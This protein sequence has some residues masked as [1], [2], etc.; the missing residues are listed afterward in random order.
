MSLPSNLSL[1]IQHGPFVAPVG[2]DTSPVV[3]NIPPNDRETGKRVGSSRPTIPP[4][5]SS[6]SLLQYVTTNYTDGSSLADYSS[7]NS[8]S[9]PTRG[10]HQHKNRQRMP[11]PQFSGLGPRRIESNDALLPLERELTYTRRS[12]VWSFETSSDGSNQQA[13]QAKTLQKRTTVARHVPHSSVQADVEALFFNKA[14]IEHGK[15][16]SEVPNLPKSL[17][18]WSDLSRWSAEY[19][20]FSEPDAPAEQDGQDDLARSTQAGESANPQAHGSP[21]PAAPSPAA[22]FVPINVVHRELLQPGIASQNAQHAVV[23]L[24]DVREHLS[25][26]VFEEQ[27]RSE[28]LRTAVLQNI[29]LRTELEAAQIAL[30]KRDEEFARL[31]ELHGADVIPLRAFSYHSLPARTQQASLRANPGTRASNAGQSST[32]EASQKVAIEDQDLTP[33]RFISRV[34]VYDITLPN[35]RSFPHRRPASTL[36]GSSCS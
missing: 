28:G 3:S 15:A 26:L 21:F 14:E 36:R 12:D 16:E 27:A 23:L 31:R 19:D 35:Q 7:S 32:E 2:S 6:K 25:Q 4:R 9:P 13:L 30:R 1:F 18:Q 17:T 34:P 20:Q 33:R 8:S 29:H 10:P 24:S 22:P 5:R 11:E